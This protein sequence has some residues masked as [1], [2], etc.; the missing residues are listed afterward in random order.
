MFIGL[1]LQD[2][3]K[4]YGNITYHKIVK[5]R[6][7]KTNRGYGFINYSTHKSALLAIEN[8]NKMEIYGKTLKVSFARPPCREIRDSKL[9]ILNLPKW[10]SIDS[11]VGLFGEV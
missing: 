2:L 5:D 6:D 3:F 8:L 9:H 11:L 1:V 10:L 4:K 7:T